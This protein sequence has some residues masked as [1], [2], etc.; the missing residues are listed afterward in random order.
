MQG[1]DWVTRYSA[2]GHP[3]QV[4]ERPLPRIPDEW[5]DISIYL[6]ASHADAVDGKRTGGSGFLVHYDFENT[7]GRGL[8]YAV[9]NAHVIEQGSCTIRVNTKAGDLDVIDLDERHWII[10]ASRDDIAVAPHRTR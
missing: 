8:V 4:W 10:P 2:A 9:T 3:F 7:P 1:T 6:Y 5:L